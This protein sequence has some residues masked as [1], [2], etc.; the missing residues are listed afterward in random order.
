MDK[1]NNWDILREYIPKF[2]SE[3]LKKKKKKRE[4]KFYIPTL[5]EEIYEY[6]EYLKNARQEEIEKHYSLRRY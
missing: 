1:M 5:E 6:K 3:D 2:K 4:S